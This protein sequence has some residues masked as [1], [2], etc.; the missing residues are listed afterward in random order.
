MEKECKDEYQK[1]IIPPVSSVLR[2][3][4][5]RIDIQIDGQPP[6]RRK[7][8]PV[9]AARSPSRESNLERKMSRDTRDIS[10]WFYHASGVFRGRPTR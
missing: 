9:E 6:A 10:L 3:S 2:V 7:A 4:V 5:D 8:L 1:V